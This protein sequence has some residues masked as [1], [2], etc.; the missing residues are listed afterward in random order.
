MLTMLSLTIHNLGQVTLVRCAGRITADSGNVLRDGVI[1]HVHTH[2]AVLDMGEVSAVDAAGLG[3][4]LSVR[5][6][7]HA[8]GRELKLLNLSPRL[9][10]LL[11]LTKLRSVLDVCS[12]SDMMDLL[13]RL[14]YQL[15]M[16]TDAATSTYVAAPALSNELQSSPEGLDKSSDARLRF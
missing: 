5:G 11:E 3:M 2:T 8:T 6:W 13:C 7:A 9:E 1:T 12:A 16:P 4:F 10:K 15:A 14:R